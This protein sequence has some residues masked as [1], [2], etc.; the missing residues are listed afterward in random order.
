MTDLSEIAYS[1]EVICGRLDELNQKIDSGIEVY[2][3]VDSYVDPDLCK[4]IM[5]ISESILTVNKTLHKD[6]NRIIATIEKSQKMLD[7]KLDNISHEIIE[8]QGER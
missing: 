2:G 4:A 1:T 7:D 5:S 3:T 6:L 8:L